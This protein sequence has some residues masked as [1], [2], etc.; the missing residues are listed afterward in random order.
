MK[1]SK[2]NIVLLSKLQRPQIKTKTLYRKRLIDLLS[3][4]L[5][6]KVILLC[7]GAGYGKTTLLS[8]FL[9]ETKIPSVYYHL[10]DE[11]A[12]PVVFFSYLIAGIRRIKPEFGKKIENLRNFFNY[13]ERYLEIIV[14][15]FINEIM[16][17]IKKDLYII[18]E[19]YHLLEQS[20][21]IDKIL[22]Y[23]LEHLPS[24]LHFIIT[25]RTMPSISLSRFRARDEILEL[26][27]QHL[28]FT[29]D[30]IM[31]L[32]KEMYSIS[33][34]E[35]ELK[36]I[37]EHSEGWPTSLR[38]MIQ[39]SDYLE[40]IKSSGYVRRVLNSYYQSQSNLFNYFAQ[41]IYNQESKEIRRFLVDC[42]VLEWL[43]PGLCDA[44]TRRKNS[45]NV[46]SNL[47]TRNAFLVRIPGQDYRFHN[48]FRNFLHS[49]LTDV[50]R[51]KRIC[52]RAGDFYSRGDRL[53]EALKF[54][55]KAGEF[56]R[57]ASIIEKIGFYLIGPGRSGVLSYYI[58]QIP[59][60]IRNQFPGLLM[61]YAQSLIHIGRSD[62]AKNNYLK[63]A[64]I[65]K[66]RKRC[67]IKYAAALY[68]LGGLSLNQ[69]KF[70]VAKKWFR[71]ALSVCPK[72]SSLTR[73]AILNSLGFVY[74][75]I[76]GRNLGKATKYFGKALQ[77]A[78]KNRYKKLEASIFNNWAMNEWKAGN[79]NQAYLRLSK[80]VKLLKKHFS[81]HC[82]SGFFNASRLSALMGNK[83]E[84][85]SILNAG[86]KTCGAYN[87]LWS[88]GT[89]WKG[90]S[91]LYQELGDLQ[92]AKQF[93]AKS[94][95]IYEKLG[96]VRLMI[97]ALNELSRINI[98]AGDLS[99]AEKNLSAIWWFKKNRNDP[100]SIPILLTEARLKIAQERFDKAKS[101]L[102]QA[103]KLTQ[104]FKQIFNSFL[105][106]IEMSKVY[107]S[108]G[109]VEKALHAL[110]KAIMISRSKGYDY[111]LLQE[112]Q[113]EKWMLQAIKRENIEKRYVMSIIKKSKLDI[114]WIDAFLFGVPKVF[115][116]DCEITDDAWKTIKA[117]KFF[118]YLL[119][120]KNEKIS[121][122]SIIAA[123]WPNVSYKSG[124]YS[125]RKARQHIRQ[126]FKSNVE[127]F[128][129]LIVSSKDLYQISTQVS[130]RLDTDEFQNLV[131]QSKGLKNEDEKLKSY[132]QR[133]L[134]IYKKGFAVGWYDNWVEDVRH[135]YQGLY[136]DC[137]ATLADFYLRKNK[138]KD[139]INSYKKL[140]LLNFYNEDYHRKLMLSY[141]KL[142]RYKE[143]K[144]NFEKLK[145]VL[146]KEL[147]SE[148]QQKTI[149]L[150]KSLIH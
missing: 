84:A 1:K 38:L 32:F 120:H 11:D 34:K 67:R 13:P 76:G 103:L 60:P 113:K 91:I 107:Y 140:L 94:L 74:T 39:S 2:Q 5:G 55:L 144:Q 27:N 42:S 100:E 23:L 111:L 124:R 92:K 98:L 16:A 73:A 41:E 81:P 77:I 96:I 14:G 37:E 93:I 12:E 48:L 40:G 117:K 22:I 46:L 53:E 8:Q 119:L 65:F 110:E 54:Y 116:D 114:H 87:D 66:Q 59:S 4:N 80:I 128:G 69:S 136:E 21:Q 142:G 31:H 79:L 150:Y 104:R 75:Q 3:K 58:E 44:V 106:N 61:N 121:F 115:I 20:A 137:L 64:K 126:A 15:T 24:C 134:S 62:E 51:E 147:R 49:K 118:F 17:N 125:F 90:Y 43:T 30:E 26:K 35:T 132:L 86:I 129:D 45:A 63:A 52:R 145:E 146:R 47:T 122:D 9:S 99:E 71:S 83:K 149:N 95:E 18:L 19:D 143:I 127:G 148:P 7:A 72:G 108:Q 36:W 29:K 133:T 123:V 138:L 112:L 131:M 141:A 105:I 130:V 135:Y 56:K 85:R 109:K 6:K 28:R 10:E 102:T 70:L 33:L 50:E 88:M 139:A 101:I 97:T 89:L 78:Q 68:E 25:S 57:A 82:G